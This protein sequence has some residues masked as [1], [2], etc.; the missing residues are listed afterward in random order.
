MFLASRQ[1]I[2]NVTVNMLELP[3]LSYCQVTKYLRLVDFSQHL[4]KVT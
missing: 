1:F 2:E 3:V 4:F